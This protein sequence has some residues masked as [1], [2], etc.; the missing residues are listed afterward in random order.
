MAHNLHITLFYQIFQTLMI[1]PNFLFSTLL[2]AVHCG[3]DILS[4][5]S[6]TSIYL[7]QK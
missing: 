4:L 5:M 6:L 1:F 2:A 3:I 7:H